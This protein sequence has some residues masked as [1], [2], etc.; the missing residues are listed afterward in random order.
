MQLNFGDLERIN[1]DTGDGATALSSWSI[2]GGW[3]M[4]QRMLQQRNYG[5]INISTEGNFVDF[6]DLNYSAI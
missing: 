6:G 1:I 4:I 5:Y 2:F 3:W